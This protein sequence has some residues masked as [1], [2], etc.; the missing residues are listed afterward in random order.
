MYKVLVI[1]STEHILQMKTE[2]DKSGLSFDY[3]IA[4]NN[5]TYD[6]GSL[7]DQYL[8]IDQELIPFSEKVDL[9]L[10]TE[11]QRQKKMNVDSQMNQLRHILFQN[12]K[13]TKKSS[14]S[15]FLNDATNG[16]LSEVFYF[17]DVVD[18]KINQKDKKIHIEILK[19]GVR[20]Y[21]HVLVEESYLNLSLFSEKFKQQDLFDF[22]T[23]QVFQ[24]VGM[25][26][27]ISE[28]LGNY[29]FW[30]MSDTNYNSIYD[31]LYYI[32]VRNSIMDVWL[33]LPAQQ[34]KNPAT[35]GYFT[36]RAHKHLVKK[37]DFLNFEIGSESLNLQPINTY[38]E[39]GCNYKNQITF[40]PQFHFYSPMQMTKAVGHL[41]DTVMKKLKI[42]KE[43]IQSK[44]FE[45]SV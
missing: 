19:S 22:Q 36:E 42:K 4:N 9:K 5:S 43:F 10:L 20:S 41:S 11:S 13:M 12:L 45:E 44:N 34:L 26:F 8:N 28:D 24:F 29:K 40:L 27:K 2:F 25:K 33:W 35:Q 1:A 38:M 23:Q 31:N 39:S 18:L 15:K 37:F 7:E 21:D 30:S 6:F 3:L 14:T 32:S 16:N 17:D